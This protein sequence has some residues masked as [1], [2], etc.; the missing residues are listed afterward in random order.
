[1]SGSRR[2]GTPPWVTLTALVLIV[3]MVAVAALSIFV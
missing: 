2:S 1:M 3:A